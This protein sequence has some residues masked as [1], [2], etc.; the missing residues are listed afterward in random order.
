M[1]PK[2]PDHADFQ[3]ISGYFNSTSNEPKVKFG[4]IESTPRNQV[5]TDRLHYSLFESVDD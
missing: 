4:S 2:G 1:V 5:I 3:Q